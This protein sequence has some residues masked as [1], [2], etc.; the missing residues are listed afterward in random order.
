MAFGL[1]DR[2]GLSM[3]HAL[4]IVSVAIGDG[5]F[6]NEPFL[7]SDLLT[8]VGLSKNWEL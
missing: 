8:F 5:M 3:S 7:L 4:F 6:P 2:T 1:G